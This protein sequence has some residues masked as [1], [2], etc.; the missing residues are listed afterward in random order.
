M[1]NLAFEEYR[2]TLRHDYVISGKRYQISM[3]VESRMV[4]DRRHGMP[5]SVVVNE[6]LERLRHYILDSIT[7][8]DVN[9]K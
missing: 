4:V 9:A 6:M 1:D 3:P 7:E 2:L 5:Q 8:E